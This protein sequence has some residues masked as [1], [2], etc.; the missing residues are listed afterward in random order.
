MTY[1]PLCSFALPPAVLA[2]LALATGSIAMAAPDPPVSVFGA[3]WEIALSRSFSFG[4]K[5]GIRPR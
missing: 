5:P 3:G 2:V 1:L 4:R